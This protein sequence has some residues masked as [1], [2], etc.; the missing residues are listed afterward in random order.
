MV[1][2][3]R[4]QVQ[5][6]QQQQQPVFQ[7]LPAKSIILSLEDKPR[8]IPSLCTSALIVSLHL[9]QLLLLLMP[10]TERRHLCYFLKVLRQKVLVAMT[11]IKIFN[12]LSII[13]S[14]GRLGPMRL[15]TYY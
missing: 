2:T 12:L 4:M 14:K 3:I 5:L 13:L 15:P 9:S 1:G 11:S 10:T 7:L 6:Q 8:S